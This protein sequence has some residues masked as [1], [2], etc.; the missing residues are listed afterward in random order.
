MAGKPAAEQPG[1]V[2]EVENM[3]RQSKRSFG[4]C[5]I[6]SLALA[7][8]AG[9]M[10]ERTPAQDSS[11]HKAGAAGTKASPKGIAQQKPVPADLAKTVLTEPPALAVIQNK[12]TPPPAP[13]KRFV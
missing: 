8:A 10:L 5:L 11:A 9:L 12:S 7:G 1:F 4:A 3:V 2:T 13:G 6:G